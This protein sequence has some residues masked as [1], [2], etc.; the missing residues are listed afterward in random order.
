MLRFGNKAA[1]KT[2]PATTS[3]AMMEPMEGRVLMSITITD[4][5]VSSFSLGGGGITPFT[6]DGRQLVVTIKDGPAA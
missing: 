5:M 1:E 4:A 3:R 2:H 6:P